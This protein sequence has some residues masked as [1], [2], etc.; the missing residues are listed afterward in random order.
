LNNNNFPAPKGNISVYV[1]HVNLLA[2]DL[3]ANLSNVF[4]LRSCNSIFTYRNFDNFA[5]RHAHPVSVLIIPN[6]CEGPA[7]L[8]ARPLIYVDSMVAEG[9]YQNDR[10][11]NRS[12]VFILPYLRPGK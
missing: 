8:G 6:I 9:F 11:N 5:V 3:F 10:Y 1:C 2:R 7:I 4:H 12:L